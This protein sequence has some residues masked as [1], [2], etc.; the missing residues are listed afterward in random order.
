M[1]AH[2]VLSVAEVAPLAQVPFQ[3]ISGMYDF[4]EANPVPLFVVFQKVEGFAASSKS[5]PPTATLKGVEAE[6]LICS[7]S[8]ETL[9]RTSG[10][11]PAEPLSPAATITVMPCAAACSH[12]VSS[13]ASLAKNSH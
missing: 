7:P 13:K 6:P 9:A 12:N 3:V 8:V 1:L 5:V 11:Q 4:A 10:S 2:E